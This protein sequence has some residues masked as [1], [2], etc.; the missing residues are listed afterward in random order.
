[1]AAYQLHVSRVLSPWS[2]PVVLLVVLLLTSPS[3]ALQDVAV[4]AVRSSLA[5]SPKPKWESKEA[6]EVGTEGVSSS[7]ESFQWKPEP[8]IAPSLP[9]GFLDH[10]PQ[11][12]EEIAP[13]EPS[14]LLGLPVTQLSIAPIAVSHLFR[15]PLPLSLFQ[16]PF[17]S[18][19]G[20]PYNPLAWPYSPSGP[21][22]SIS[23]SPKTS[24]H[25]THIHT[26][27][28]PP[29]SLS[30]A[31][32][33]SKTRSFRGCLATRKTK[34]SSTKDPRIVQA[35]VSQ[36]E[37]LRLKELET[38]LPPLP[39]KSTILSLPV[40]HLLCWVPVL[41]WMFRESLQN[42]EASL[43]VRALWLGPTP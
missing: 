42:G 23:L 9:W 21:Y 20:P 43:S 28:D 31:P 11:P 37:K 1:M 7:A 41:P 29:A 5:L 8:C 15:C 32:T 30:P 17:F 6:G 33:A 25:F 35:R 12:E 38:P 40:P 4:T 22:P 2:S 16:S 26:D 19:L 10:V 24:L 18:C 14:F 13:C 36:Y 3:P 34:L 39:L 27:M